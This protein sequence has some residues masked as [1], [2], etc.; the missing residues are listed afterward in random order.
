MKP[1]HSLAARHACTIT[2]LRIYLEVVAIR[3]FINAKI[4]RWI[5]NRWRRANSDATQSLII[6]VCISSAF[7]HTFVVGADGLSVVSHRT[8]H[9]T[10]IIV[11]IFIACCAVYDTHGV[12]CSILQLEEVSSVVT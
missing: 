7:L 4:G 12:S 9:H 11:I 8:C 2:E 5:S 10:S 6:S 3:T 1:L